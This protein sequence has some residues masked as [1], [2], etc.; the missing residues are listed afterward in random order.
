LCLRFLNL[1]KKLLKEL[2]KKKSRPASAEELMAGDL[3]GDGKLDAK[4]L[5]LMK[6]LLSTL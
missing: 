5:V 1:K 6:Q 2:T 4:D 3:N